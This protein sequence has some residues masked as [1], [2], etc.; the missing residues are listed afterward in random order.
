MI[1]LDRDLYFSNC[2]YIRSKDS[3]TRI[4]RSLKFSAYEKRFKDREFSISATTVCRTKM[5]QNAEQNAEQ[6][7]RLD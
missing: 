1:K 3:V 2:G 6:N 4:E 7:C 5:R